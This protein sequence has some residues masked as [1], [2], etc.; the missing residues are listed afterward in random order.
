MHSKFGGQIFGFD[1]DQNGTE[2]VLSEAKGLNNGDVL[3]AV[4]T[5]DQATGKILTVVGETRTQDNFLTLGIVGTSVGL[6]E[7]E[8]VTG[9]F[10]DEADLRRTESAELEQVHEHVE[11]A[12][13]RRSNHSR[14][15]PQSGRRR[16]RHHCLRQ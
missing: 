4:E 16:D 11:G 12:F 14:G 13:D 15:Q 3:A 10:V 5:F 6:V 9:L 2:G 7:R 1:I 8:H